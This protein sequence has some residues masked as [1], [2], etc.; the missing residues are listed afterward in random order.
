MFTSRELNTFISVAE[1][2]SIKLAAEELNITSPAVCSMIKK[3]ESRINNKLFVF[4]NNKMIL[5]QYGKRIYSLTEGHFHTLRSLEFKMRGDKDIIKVFICEELSFLS[6]FIANQFNKREKETILT[7]FID[8]STDLII[9][10][11]SIIKIDPCNYNI[12]PTNLFL[13]L[14]NDVNSTSRD[15]FIHKEHAHL[16]NNHLT[17]MAADGIGKDMDAESKVIVS[18]NITSIVEMV[19]SSLGSAILPHICSV[20]KCLA[21]SRL[22]L[23]IKRITPHIPMHVYTHKRIDCEMV[24]I[25]F[26]DIKIK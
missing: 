4:E 2:M 24:K 5:T 23:K 20:L 10:D 3:L 13:Y 17:K 18:E 9:N 21:N 8:D 6:S 26:D 15:I 25:I 22:E 16:I 14:V 7:T 1:K 19:I 12:V 11:E